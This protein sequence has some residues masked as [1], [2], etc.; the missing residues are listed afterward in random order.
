MI[1]ALMMTVAISLASPSLS[2]PQ[3][4]S[5]PAPAPAPAAVAPVEN[6][7]ILAP[8]VP[9][10][11]CGG[12]LKTPAYCISAELTQVGALAEQYIDAMA[13]ESWLAADGDENRVIF[14]RR[15]PDGTCDGMQMVAFYDEARPV[16]P[17]TLGYL[18][19]AQIPG[20]ICRAPTAQGPASQ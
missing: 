11:D 3:A 16:G 20:N 10:P 14:V 4:S 9:A 2:L 1:T 12:L 18:G 13:K 17:T 19:F 8:A 7:P 15:K 5:T 6:F